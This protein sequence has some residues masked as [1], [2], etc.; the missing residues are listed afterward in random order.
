MGSGN[1]RNHAILLQ[2]TLVFFSA[3]LMLFVL[4][5]LQ[6]LKHHVLGQLYRQFGCSNK[7]SLR[8]VLFILET[9]LYMV[10]IL[11]PQLIW[12][13]LTPNMQTE[14]CCRICALFDAVKPENVKC[15]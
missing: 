2:S 8:Y 14:E 5:D 15:G 13:N 11:S 9:T 7:G 10:F 6:I 12:Q 3:E 4:S 1:I